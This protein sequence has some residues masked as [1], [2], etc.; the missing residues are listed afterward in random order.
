MGIPVPP[1]PKAADWIR[2]AVILFIAFC[3]V[4]I[5]VSSPVTAEMTGR[6]RDR[7]QLEEAQ[8]DLKEAHDEIKRLRERLDSHMDLADRALASINR[9]IVEIKSRFADVSWLK[10]WI[11]AGTRKQS[12]K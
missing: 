4:L 5:V 9:D 10:T 11:Q 12:Q 6:S 3:L 1:T 8:K 7:I 2:N